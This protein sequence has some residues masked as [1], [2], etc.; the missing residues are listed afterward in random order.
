MLDVP[1]VAFAVPP[2]GWSVVTETTEPTRPVALPPGVGA[3]GVYPDP[4]AP[5]LASP[6][7]ST[8]PAARPPTTQRATRCAPRDRAR[9]RMATA[10][11]ATTCVASV[12]IDAFSLQHRGMT[13]VH[14]RR[15]RVHDGSSRWHARSRRRC[16]CALRRQPRTARAVSH[17][18]RRSGRTHGHD[19][20]P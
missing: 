14:R 2:L 1:I 8:P 16:G 20:G 18:D 13:R 12:L 19:R 5:A 4:A 10:P 3:L 15:A 7:K 17:G 11:F 6:S 9:T